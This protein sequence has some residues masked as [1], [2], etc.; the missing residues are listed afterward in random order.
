MDAEII[1]FPKS[2]IPE[3]VKTPLPKMPEPIP[4]W[5]SLKD[6]CRVVA[7]EGVASLLLD[8]EKRGVKLSNEEILGLLQWLSGVIVKKYVS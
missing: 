6:H 7:T 4:E 5:L 3:P 1:P 8:L 2:K